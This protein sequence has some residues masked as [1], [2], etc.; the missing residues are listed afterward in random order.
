MTPLMWAAMEGNE[1]VAQLLI[2]YRAKMDSL[3][4]VSIDTCATL[5]IYSREG[6]S[7]TLTLTLCLTLSND[8]VRNSNPRPML[9]P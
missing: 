4:Q 5:T 3:T 8:T 2:D 6:E 7:L 9:N 1:D